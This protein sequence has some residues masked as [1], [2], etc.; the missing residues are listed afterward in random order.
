ME[1]SFSRAFKLQIQIFKVVRLHIFLLFEK[2]EAGTR[3]GS[4]IK[5]TGLVGR[6]IVRRGGNLGQCHHDPEISYL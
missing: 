2:Q 1:I 4:W 6:E 5:S 3:R